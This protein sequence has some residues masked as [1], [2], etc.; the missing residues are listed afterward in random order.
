MLTEHRAELM[1]AQDACVRVRYSVLSKHIPGA[2]DTTEDD[3][4]SPLFTEGS[5]FLWKKVRY[6]EVNR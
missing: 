2:E 5:L 4:I 3:S 1:Y 6:A